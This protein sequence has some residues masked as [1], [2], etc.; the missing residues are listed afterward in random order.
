MSDESTPY[1][2]KPEVEAAWNFPLF[3]AL[4]GR[5]S[6]RFGFGMEL[7][8]GPYVYRSDK[9]PHPLTEDEI[10]MLVAAGFT[11]IVD[12]IGG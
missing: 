11:E 10:A 5:R 8:H 7:E 1:G 4:M 12:R 2:M 6:R 3:E 9:E